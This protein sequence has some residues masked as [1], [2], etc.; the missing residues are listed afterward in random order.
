MKK[1]ANV[2]ALWQCPKCGNRF[3]ARNLWH[4]CV[5]VPLAAHF[6]GKG[7]IVRRTFAALLRA[8]QRN[9]PVAVVSSKTRIT[10]MVRM[11]FA[12]VTPRKNSLPGH[13][14]VPAR[15]RAA[16]LRRGAR[17]GRLQLHPFC[18][19][20]PKQIDRAFRRLLAEAY[21]V[22]QQKH[23]ERPAKTR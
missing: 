3:V 21:A 23:L 1:L 11:R 4:S 7:P 22:G 8:L 19:T 6:K 20:H 16:R 9:G 17:Y 12:G 10:F 2:R 5:R 18:L 14:L 15:V 13:L